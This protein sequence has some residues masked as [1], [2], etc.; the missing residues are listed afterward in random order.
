MSLDDGLVLYLPLSEGY[1]DRVWDRSQGQNNGTVYGATWVDGKYG[2]ALS[3]DGVDDY[4]EVPDSP[5][6]R[7]GT[8]FSI[9]MWTYRTKSDI[10]VLITKKVTG[11]R[12]NYYTYHE[13]EY[14]RFFIADTD[15]NFYTCSVVEPSKN[16]WHHLT[17][18]WDGTTMHIYIDGVL[19]NSVYVGTI[20]LN[21][22]SGYNLFIGTWAADYAAPFGGI[23]DEVCIYNRALSPEEIR[24]LY[25]KTSGRH[26]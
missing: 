16:A 10:N 24:T 20:T 9:S 23:I 12:Y 18:V 4:A 3:F 19:A 15:L 7:I 17:F 5:S 14:L 22:A 13:A 26:G 2:K 8:P 21:D 1:G 6:L 11:N 25:T